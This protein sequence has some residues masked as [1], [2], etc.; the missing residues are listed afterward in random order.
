LAV[1]VVIRGDRSCLHQLQVERFKEATAGLSGM[2]RHIANSAATPAT[3]RRASTRFAAASPYTESRRSALIH[4]RTGLPAL[5]W[6]SHLA[7]VKLVAPGESTGYGRRFV[8]DRPTWI[9]IVPVG[10]QTGSG[11]T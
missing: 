8:A 3:R 4:E 1:A 6:E 7:L 11:G 2:T 5:R 9:G 10:T